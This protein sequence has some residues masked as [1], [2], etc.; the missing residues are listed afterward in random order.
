[1]DF[2]LPRTTRSRHSPGTGKR[3]RG[4]ATFGSEKPGA[5]YLCTTKKE[6]RIAH[7]LVA[8][9]KF[10]S[11]ASAKAVAAA[12]GRAVAAAGHVAE[13]LPLADGGE[14][15]LEVV[16]GSLQTTTVHGPLGQEVA[17]AWR[18][19]DTAPG[20]AQATAVIEMAAAS[21]L[22]LVGGAAGNDPMAASTRGTGELIEAALDAGAKRI[23]V[24]LGGSATTDGGIGA[25]EVLADDARLRS[26]ELLVACDV[27]TTFVFAA[28]VFGPQKGAT[29]AMVGLLGRRLDA[30]AE[31]YLDR[32]GVDVREIPGSGAA[33]GLGGGLAVLGGKLRSG[34]ELV[35]DLLGLD[36]AIERADL[37]I[38]G[39]GRLDATS[40]TGKVVG[41]LRERVGGRSD[42]ACIVGEA[43]PG[44]LALAGDMT[45]LS[46]TDRY[47]A[48]KA[49]SETEALIEATCAAFLTSWPAER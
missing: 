37:V 49:R 5:K 45:V 34:F 26:T 27:T 12:C 18:F 16:G 14:G 4:A 46:L 24:G 40:F 20:S 44:A 25:L 1:L 29:P 23:I 11:T 19:L 30:L 33:G 41:S 21:G 15:L 3:Y 2:A 10:R 6:T 47:G 13:L 9:D 28:E 48:E 22:E 35:A 42:V 36:R 38:T 8:P 32:F 17:A 31:H 39:E 43:T 7:V